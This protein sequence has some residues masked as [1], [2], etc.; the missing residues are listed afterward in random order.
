MRRCLLPFGFGGIVGL[1]AVPDENPSRVGSV[2]CLAG[3]A[4]GK[5]EVEAIVV[6]VALVVVAQAEIGMETALFEPDKSE[7]PLRVVQRL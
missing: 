1:P 7:V 4:H 3:P 5:A 6:E 2:D